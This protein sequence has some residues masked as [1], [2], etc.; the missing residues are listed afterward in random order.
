MIMMS[1]TK[2]RD[3][4]GHSRSSVTGRET[5]EDRSLIHQENIY[6]ILLPTGQRESN[7]VTCH[8]RGLY[9]LTP[10]LYKY[11]GFIAVGQM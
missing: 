2:L 8:A 6:E 1:D 3:R 9:I 7:A 10:T 11:L 5:T 4:K